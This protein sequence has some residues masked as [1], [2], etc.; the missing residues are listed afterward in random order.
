MS[1]APK[2][3]RMTVAAAAVLCLLM[4]VCLATVKGESGGTARATHGHSTDHGRLSQSALAFHD[5][6]RKLWE[7]HIAYTRNV[8]ISFE[9][10]VPAAGTVLPDL[11]TVVG[12]LQQNQVDIGNAIKPYYGNAAGDQLASLLHDHITGA[13]AV[14]KALKTGDQAGL[15]SALHAWYANAHEIAV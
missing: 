8:I 3:R 2:S 7:D 4:A 5:A 10:D 13:A 6:M 9:L 15:Q 11:N 12:R 1:K 14:L